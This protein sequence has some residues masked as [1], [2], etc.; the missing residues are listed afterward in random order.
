[1]RILAIVQGE[2]GQRKVENIR[3]HGPADWKVES[4]RAPSLLPP[5]LD[6]P[7][8]YLP[9]TL[10]PADLVLVLGEHPGVAELVPDVVRMC[11]A[12]AVIAPIDNN[13][14]L[15]KGLARQLAGWLADLGVVAVFPKPFCALT[16]THTG[17]RRFRVAYDH[18]LIREFARYFGQP[19]LRITCDPESRRIVAAEV[20]RDACCGCARYVA[21]RLVGVHADDAEQEA[22]M[23]H[24]H[25]PCLASMGIDPDFD[26][27]LM[28][29]SGNLLRDDVGAQVKPFKQVQVFVPAGRV[30]ED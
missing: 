22:G 27:T 8:D 29:V 14:W 25:Y 11:G 15:P 10:P 7:E 17:V 19:A 9:A 28:H 1:M 30:D 3:R 2:Y 4:W 24:H 6:Y 26:D 18:P 23:L 5:V 21:E 12:Q 16:E 13:A 20:T